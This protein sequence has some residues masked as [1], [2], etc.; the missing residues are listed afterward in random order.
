M[1]KNRFLGSILP[2]LIMYLSFNSLLLAQNH[3]VNFHLEGI[4]YDSLYIYGIDVHA[5]KIKIPGRQKDRNVWTFSIPDSIY[6]IVPQFQLAPKS[7]DLKKYILYEIEFDCVINKD[8]LK[9]LVMN[10]N[11]KDSIVQ[12]KYAGRSSQDSTYIIIKKKGER[13]LVK[14]AEMRDRFLVSTEDD[15]DLIIRAKCPTFSCF[16][17]LNGKEDEYEYFLKQYMVLSAKYPDSKYLI[18][19][20]SQNLTQ[21]KS[22]NDIVK[23]FN[24]LSD[25]YKQTYWGKRIKQY[26]NRNVFVNSILPSGETNVPK[27]IIE[28][29]TKYNLVVFSASWCRPCREEIPLLQ[30]IFSDLHER[31]DIVY[32]S[33]DTPETVDAWKA[34]MRKERIPW[35]SVLAAKQIEKIKEKYFMEVVPYIILVYPGGIMR[36]IDIRDDSDR[37][38]L[39]KLV[40]EQTK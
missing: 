22:K 11:D 29:T 37:A 27:A 23:V 36:K 39:Y 10:F 24:H 26:L 28:D 13:I 32:V 2:V 38:Q 16:Y 17:N 4:E 12:A 5:Q 20:L 9:T 7:A 6:N 8:T 35:R 18:I 33:I 30:K 25:R 19:N 21:Y 31:L 34:L 40:R 1:N 3:V 15:S 14:A